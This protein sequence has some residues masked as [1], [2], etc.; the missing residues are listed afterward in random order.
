V[1]NL[2]LDMFFF[3]SQESCV[4]ENVWFVMEI[5]AKQSWT[6]L[7]DLST[8]LYLQKCLPAYC[9]IILTS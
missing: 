7:A 5:C 8:K 6:P 3:S 1:K 4:E 2:E 9:S